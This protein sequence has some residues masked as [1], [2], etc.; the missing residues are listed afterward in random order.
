MLMRIANCCW[1]PNNTRFIHAIAALAVLAASALHTAPLMA[2]GLDREE[3]IEAIVGSEVQTEEHQAQVEEERIAAAIDN[4]FEAASEARKAFSLDGLKIIFL[5]DIDERT[6]A[7]D[8]AISENEENIEALRQA[9]RG[10]AM[11][12][13]AVNSRNI[14]INDIVALEFGEGNSATVFVTGEEPNG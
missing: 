5:P 12:F 8:A 3:A 11:L 13:H 7:I 10:S 9:I 14:D 1:F 6:P 2:Q 4:T